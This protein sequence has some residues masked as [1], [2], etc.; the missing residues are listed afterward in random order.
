MRMG[1]GGGEARRGEECEGRGV[2]GRL[3]D[4]VIWGVM[5]M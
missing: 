3:G 4:K 2:G 5:G 1:Q